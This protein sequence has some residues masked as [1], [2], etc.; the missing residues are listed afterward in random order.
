MLQN[1]YN[2]TM[3]QGS[4]FAT[5]IVLKNSDGSL[6]DLTNYEA[7]MQIRPSYDS[8]IVTEELST[9]NN[10]I[11]IDVNTAT[12]QIE[13]HADRTAAIPVD[14][15]NVRN[16]KIKANETARLPQTVYVYDLEIFEANLVQKILYGEVTVYGEVTR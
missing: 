3:F 10:E 4:T 15:T 13:L 8:E 6:K 12:I 7:R 14:L 5:T 2:L 16:V 11:T 9:A 1:K